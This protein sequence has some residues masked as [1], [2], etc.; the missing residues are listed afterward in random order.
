[1]T[2]LIHDLRMTA[3]DYREPDGI[4]GPLLTQAADEIERLSTPA[5]LADDPLA[6]YQ[7]ADKHSLTVD[8]WAI[9]AGALAG[10]VME[11]KRLLRLER[12]QHQDHHV[13]RRETYHGWGHTEHP[14]EQETR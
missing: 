1:M 13:E 3:Q 7:A 8:E 10:Q 5:N 6:A 11:L 14:A 4:L 9:L 2:Q 12:D